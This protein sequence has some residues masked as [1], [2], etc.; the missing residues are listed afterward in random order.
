MQQN[1]NLD[2]PE[3]K[4]NYTWDFF[5]SHSGPDRELAETL[6]SALA[7]PAKVFLDSISLLPGDNFDV[8]L[9]EALHSSLISV[10]LISPNTGNAYYEQEEIAIAINRTRE[11]PNTHRV[12]PVYIN[13]KQIPPEK[14]PIGLTRKHSLYISDQDDIT[15]TGKKLLKTLDVMKHYEIRKDRIVEEQQIAVLKIT[16]P[17][18]N[19]DL[20]SGFNEVTRFVRVPLYTLFALFFLMLAILVTCIIIPS[21]FR[22]LLI[23]II[24]SLC[25]LLLGGIFWLIARSLRYAPQIAQGKINGN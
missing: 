15:E 4:T 21:E 7:P 10:I 24:G 20:I 22:G 6:Y 16:N 9:T 25:A 3:W 23:T 13:S 5:L 14:I 19:A 11:D 17:R 12:V 8:T 2:Q 1:A 18:T